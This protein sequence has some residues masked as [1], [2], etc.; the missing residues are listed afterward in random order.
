MLPPWELQAGVGL[1]LGTA[2]LAQDEVRAG[3]RHMESR[4]RVG[5]QSSWV[6]GRAFV[7]WG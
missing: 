2:S 4:A 7:L 6:R 5:P 3:Q 1:G